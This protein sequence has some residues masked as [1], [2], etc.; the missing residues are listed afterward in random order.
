MLVSPSPQG[1]ERTNRGTGRARPLLGPS[2]GRS[3]LSAGPRPTGCSASW[4]P[5]SFPRL[6]DSQLSR[7]EAVLFPQTVAGGVGGGLPWEATGPQAGA[8]EGRG[9]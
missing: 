9:P 6:Q 7:Q 2:P 8:G 5:S 1:S 3:Y 4:A